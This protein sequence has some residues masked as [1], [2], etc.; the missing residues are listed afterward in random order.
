[1]ILFE[2]VGAE[3]KNPAPPKPKPNAKTAPQKNTPGKA[4]SKRRATKK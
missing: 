4:P 2:F 1:M 3:I